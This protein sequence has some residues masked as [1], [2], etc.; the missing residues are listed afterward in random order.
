MGLRPAKSHEKLSGR[1]LAD[2][3]LWGRLVTC[4]RLAIG[5]CR[6]RGGP[7]AVT[8]RRAGCQPAP[9]WF[10]DP[11]WSENSNAAFLSHLRDRTEAAYE[12]HTIQVGLGQAISGVETVRR[13]STQ[14]GCSFRVVPTESWA[15]GAFVRAPQHGPG[16]L[17]LS[18]KGIRSEFD[19]SGGGAVVVVQHAAQALAAL[20]L[21]RV[22]EMA[23]LWADQLV[24]QALVI[25]LAVIVGDEILHGCPQR[26]L[27][28][29]DHALQA[30]L[31]DA[32]HKSLRVGVQIGRPRW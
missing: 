13:R 29:E 3:I 27:P 32:A 9:H 31:L 1:R 14:L 20:D 16:K 5:P 18:H 8:N 22:A 21:T 10:F 15:C 23:G 4:G 12:G 17:L 6:L 11:V 25:A 28:E 30:G 26:L 24:R 19:S 7:A 2:E